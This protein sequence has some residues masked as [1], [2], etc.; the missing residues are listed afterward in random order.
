MKKLKEKFKINLRICFSILLILFS[1]NIVLSDTI[2]IEIEGNN[3]TDSDVII[4][5]IEEQ[6]TE[7]NNEYANY[8]IKTLDNSQLFENVSVEITDDKYVIT[9]K[10]YPNI[11]KIYFKNNERIKN[12]DLDRFSDELKL[13]N[14]NPITLNK[15]VSEVQKLYESFGYNNSEITYREEVYTDSNTADLFFNINEGKITK[16]NKILF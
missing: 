16:V 12:E 11:N 4:S 5:L 15:F 7:L 10:E 13:S 14:L 3:F 1:S 2:N 6:P 9:I 8:L